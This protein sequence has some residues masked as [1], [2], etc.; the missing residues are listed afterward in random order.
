MPLDQLQQILAICASLLVFIGSIWG[1]AWFIS[2][3]LSKLYDKIDSVKEAI[4]SKLEYHERHDDARFQTIGNDLLTIKVR[5]A[6][7]DN[8]LV[9]IPDV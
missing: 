4:L 5:N 9:A 7:K 3:K 8:K 2:G 1:L 6:A